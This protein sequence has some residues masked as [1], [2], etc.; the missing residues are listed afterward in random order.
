MTA[1]PAA[2]HQ[3]DLVRQ[4]HY[5]GRGKRQGWDLIAPS[6]SSWST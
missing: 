2:T 1:R 5:E 6:Q 4:A 3:F